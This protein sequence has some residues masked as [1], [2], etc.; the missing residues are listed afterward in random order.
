MVKRTANLL[1]VHLEKLSNE[2]SVRNLLLL[3]YIEDLLD[4]V[5]DDNS[6]PCALLSFAENCLTPPQFLN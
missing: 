3:D 2:I 4:F 1:H 6:T 5:F